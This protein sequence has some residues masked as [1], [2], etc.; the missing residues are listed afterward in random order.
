[1]YKP[2]NPASGFI[3]PANL[4]GMVQRLQTQGRRNSL[5]SGSLGSG[6]VAAPSTGDPDK[7]QS[8]LNVFSNRVPRLMND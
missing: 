3:N 8:F 1:M 7:F 2:S 6:K 4:F 5:M